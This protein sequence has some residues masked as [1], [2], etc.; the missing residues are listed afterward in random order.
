VELLLLTAVNNN[1]CTH[2]N[3]TLLKNNCTLAV[4]NYTPAEKKQQLHPED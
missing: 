3:C 4:N 2:N 1:N